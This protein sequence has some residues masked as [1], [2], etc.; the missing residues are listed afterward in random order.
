M[1]E[2]RTK[3]P[4]WAPI[5][6]CALLLLLPACNGRVSNPVEPEGPELLGVSAPQNA[7]PPEKGGGGRPAPA[8]FTVVNS[9]NVTGSGTAKGGT[10][11]NSSQIVANDMTLD[12][13]FFANEAVIAGGSTCFGDGTFTGAETI[14]EANDGHDFAT[15]Y[16]EAN[17][18]DGTPGIKYVLNRPGDI[19][20]TWLPTKEDSGTFTAASWEMSA[21]GKNNKLACTGSGTFTTATTSLVTRDC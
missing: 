8:S 12:L 1:S 18:T 15:F 4:I 9:G 16:F 6:V 17:G 3:V 7:P 19:T 14:N 2:M 20:G 21:R 5:S 11:K 10:K 13:T